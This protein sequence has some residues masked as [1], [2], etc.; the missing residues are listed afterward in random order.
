MTNNTNNS[1]IS[2]LQP[3]EV[4]FVIYHHPC[5]DGTASAYVAWKYLSN[6]FPE[7][8]VIYY[9]ATFGNQP[10]DVTGR[11]VLICDFS[12]RKDKLLS[13][14]EQA[15]NLLIIDHHKSAE[16]DLKD[17]DGKYKIFDMNHSGSVLTWM[18]FY[19]TNS[20][21][22]MIRYV[23]DRDIWKKEMENTDE[24]SSWFSTLPLEFEEYDKYLDDSKLKQMIIEKG[25]PYYEQ[26]NQ[27]INQ[28]VVHSVPK[29]SKI[30]NKYYFVCYVNSTIL[31]SDIGNKIFD[32]YPMIDFSVVYSINDFND[33]TSFSLRSTEKRT[34]V[35][36]IA[37][38]FGGGGHKCASGVRI[39]YVT[40]KLPTQTYDNGNLY[41][42]L[43]NIYFGQIKVEETEYNVV[44]LNS[45]VHKAKLGSYLLQTKYIEDKEEYQVCST[46][47]SSNKK[48]HIAA[49]W[50]YN[51]TIDETD[52]TIILDRNAEKDEN[53][54]LSWFNKD[55][56]LLT[57]LINGVKYKGFHNYLIQTNIIK[58]NK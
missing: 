4:D 18:Y 33:T 52:F 14:I 30:G 19:S 17:I 34:D 46:I 35:S 38:N 54:I 8:E 44:Y 6:K 53:K 15:K 51:G 42:L 20:I 24:F 37:F 58:T 21:P 13:L 55:D 50:N 10:P 3:D 26:N 31:K 22:L 29:F 39:D 5:S 49:V 45:S 16:I 23:E 57:T 43:D 32:I 7:R 41:W 36:Q 9:K 47:K 48:Y 2:R 1:E 12:Y 56:I 40:N 28:S 11:N 27:Y 25:L